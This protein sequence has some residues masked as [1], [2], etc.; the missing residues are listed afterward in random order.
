M[1]QHCRLQET[2]FHT[3]RV[4]PLQKAINAP[5]VPGTAV[6]CPADAE[7]F[8]LITF[9]S[10]RARQPCFSDTHLNCIGVVLVLLREANHCWPVIVMNLF[11]TAIIN[12]SFC[13]CME[14][15]IFS[16]SKKYSCPQNS[17]DPPRHVL[18]KGVLWY[19]ALYIGTR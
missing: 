17:S 7:I 18:H 10:L 9:S 19:L 4:F 12:L 6:L 13:L 2:P 8:T 11:I 16:S 1:V 3:E 5:L 15:L 14:L